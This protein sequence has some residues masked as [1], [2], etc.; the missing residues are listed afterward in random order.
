MMFWG[1]LRNVFGSKHADEWAYS[2]AAAE[3]STGRIRE[4]LMYK[5]AS[6]SGGDAAQAKALY[7]KFLA[8]TLAEDAAREKLKQNATG[9]VE[10]LKSQATAAYGATTET[11]K[12]V[13][14]TWG[15]AYGQNALAGLILALLLGWCLTYLFDGTTTSGLS[16]YIGSNLLSGFAWGAV[17]ARALPT[18]LVVLTMLA[19]LMCFRFMRRENGV[20]WLVTLIPVALVNFTLWRNHQALV[21]FQEGPHTISVADTQRTPGAT[22]STPGAHDERYNR[23]LAQFE[24]QF[25]QINP[26]SPYFDERVTNRIAARVQQRVQ[27]G[28]REE[29]ALRASVREEFGQ[30]VS[31]SIAMPALK[32]KMG[33]APPANIPEH[34]RQ[35]FIQATNSVP[36]DTPIAEYARIRDR[37]EESMNKC[38]KRR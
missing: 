37:A 6:Q 29:D 2:A 28:L 16:S 38:A 33:A 15:K 21:S 13:E 5:A 7:L 32:P 18:A 36:E 11:L 4:G 1:F 31:Q 24:M 22:S 10:Q 26:D 19:F 35:I 25:P 20:A 27:S 8:E 30:Q 12:H 14:S 9:A 23:A 34:C 3:I 17:L